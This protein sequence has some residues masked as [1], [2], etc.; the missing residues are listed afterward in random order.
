MGIH[1]TTYEAILDF[2]PGKFVTR[3]EFWTVFSRILRGDTYEGT[4]ENYYFN[5]LNALRD[6]KILT[7]INPDL[8]EVRSRVFL[9]IYR[10]AVENI[11]RATAMK[12]TNKPEEIDEE[13]EEADEDAETEEE[14]EDEE[15]TE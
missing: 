12:T 9:Q 5:H 14:I 1:T 13:S 15:A 7:N 3:A 10:A 4:D 6:A 8:I 2:M 11:A